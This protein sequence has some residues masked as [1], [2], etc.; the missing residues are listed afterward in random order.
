M[1][2]ESSTQGLPGPKK[3]TIHRL[4]D[5]RHSER[6]F[7]KTVQL[8]VLAIVVG[9]TSA[10]TRYV[11]VAPSHQGGLQQ[12]AQPQPPPPPRSGPPQ[13]NSRPVGYGDMV[14]PPIYPPASRRHE[15]F[16]MRFSVT[17]GND[18]SDYR[19]SRPY[20]D[21]YGTYGRGQNNLVFDG[22]GW[23]PERR[24]CPPS[25]Y[26]QPQRRPQGPP[27]GYRQPQP[28]RVMVYNNTVNNLKNKV[29]VYASSA[30]QPNR[31]NS[32]NPSSSGGQ[33]RK[34]GKGGKNR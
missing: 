27:P 14:S 7:M 4:S 6:P 5:G 9:L 22:R 32:S 3:A 1:S 21:G 10:C 30:S 17:L 15:Q 19:H 28:Q 13:Y 25:G 16:G 26:H 18:R 33:H 23:V 12:V 20:Y 2:C 29:T 8:L 34:G 31:P 11:V 24:G